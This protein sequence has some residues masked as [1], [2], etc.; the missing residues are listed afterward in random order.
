MSS[1]AAKQ[2][3]TLGAKLAAGAYEQLANTGQ[4][5]I[6]L[7]SQAIERGRPMLESQLYE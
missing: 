3:N 6:D 4:A 7:L 5:A 1:A 2:R